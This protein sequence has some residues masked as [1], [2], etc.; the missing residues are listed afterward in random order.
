MQGS[1]Q[2]EVLRINNMQQLH[3]QLQQRVELQWQTHSSLPH[4]PLLLL[5]PLLQHILVSCFIGSAS[6]S[7]QLHQI[8]RSKAHTITF[9]E[10][11]HTA[12]STSK[13]LSMSMTQSLSLVTLWSLVCLFDYSAYIFIHV[14]LLLT[15]HRYQRPRVFMY[16]HTR[17]N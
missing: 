12:F 6:H 2:V 8:Q 13:Q 14:I 9:I 1:Q 5:V 3:Q 16:T 15:T 4:L 17:I 7:Q 10:H 11:Q